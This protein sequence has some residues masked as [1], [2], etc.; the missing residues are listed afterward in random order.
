MPHSNTSTS[1]LNEEYGGHS[2]CSSDLEAI[3]AEIEDDVKNEVEAIWKDIQSGM[4][5]NGIQYY[6]GLAAPAARRVKDA[7]GFE[8]VLPFMSEPVA[9]IKRYLA[10]AGSKSDLLKLKS[11]KSNLFGSQ[12]SLG[13]GKLSTV[14]SKQVRAE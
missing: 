11:S 1:S 2:L 7:G 3:E 9:P 10:K 8:P 12:T 6:L 5:G 4:E 14:Q 13:Q